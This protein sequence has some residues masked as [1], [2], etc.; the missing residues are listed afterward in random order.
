MWEDVFAGR[1]SVKCADLSMGLLRGSRWT[2][3]HVRWSLL[4]ACWTGLLQCCTTGLDGWAWFWVIG[5]QLWGLFKLGSF[6][7]AFLKSD[8]RGFWLLL[9][10]FVLDDL[11]V[12]QQ[13]GVSAGLGEWFDG[14]FCIL[15]QRVDMFWAFLS[16]FFL[17][18]NENHF[19]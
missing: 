14:P 16:L 13:A 10:G 19:Y 4:C 15:N 9:F 18:N 2:G 17:D 5:R 8:W 11:W 1:L 6:G 3:L 12:P 7:W